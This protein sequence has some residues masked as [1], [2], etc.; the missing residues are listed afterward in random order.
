MDVGSHLHAAVPGTMDLQKAQNL[1]TNTLHIMEYLAAN[2][3]LAK[4]LVA[5]CSAVAQRLMDDDLLGITEDLD[6]VIKNISNELHRIPVSTFASSRRNVAFVLAR[7]STSL[8]Y[9]N[10]IK[11]CTGTVY[12]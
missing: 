9:K 5:R 4:D 1:P 6:N 12:K 7:T 10:N 3:D 8:L 2:V 11:Q